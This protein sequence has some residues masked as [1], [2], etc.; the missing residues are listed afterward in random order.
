[1]NYLWTLCCCT[2][3]ALRR[4]MAKNYF[5]ATIVSQRRIEHK[6]ARW[7]SNG[8]SYKRA[9]ITVLWIGGMTRSQLFRKMFRSIYSSHMNEPSEFFSTREDSRLEVSSAR[10]W[11]EFDQKSLSCLPQRAR[12]ITVQA[13]WIIGKRRTHVCCTPSPRARVCVFLL[14]SL[15]NV[16]YRCLA[17]YCISNAANALRYTEF[18]FRVNPTGERNPCI[19]NSRWKKRK[20]EKET[21]NIDPSSSTPSSSSLHFIAKSDR[22]IET[23]LGKKH[24][25]N[26]RDKFSIYKNGNIECVLTRGSWNTDSYEFPDGN[27]IYPKGI[28]EAKLALNAWSRMVRA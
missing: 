25:N 7:Y 18:P 14:Y 8:S 19:W 9:I 5:S 26:D 17:V 15:T 23:N 2:R 12:V 22:Q 24:R 4:F 16:P 27:N 10:G 1:M 20:K 11:K 6:T 28:D 3:H 21:W 13:M